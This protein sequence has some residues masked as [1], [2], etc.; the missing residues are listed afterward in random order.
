M[1]QS[2]ASNKSVPNN[3]IP[4]INPDELKKIKIEEMRK[5]D[6]PVLATTNV[7]HGPG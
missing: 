5:K 4:L 7:A 3:E 2:K 1:K 6:K